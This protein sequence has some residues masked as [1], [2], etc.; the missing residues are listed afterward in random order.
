L[1]RGPRAYLAGAAIA[2]G[3]VAACGDSPGGPDPLPTPAPG[4]EVAVVVFYDEDGDG[5]PGSAEGARVPG[6]EVQIAGR[7]GQSE[8][9]T[10]RAVVRGVP[11]GTH[12]VSIRPASLP[13]FYSAGS[14]GTVTAPQPAGQELR[15]AVTL[16]ID[17]NR[18]NTYMAFGDSLTLGMGSSDGNG[19]RLVLQ[20]ELRGYYARGD[21]LNRG[22]DGTVANEGASRIGRGLRAF[23]P[24]YTLTLYGTNDYNNP[25]CRTDFPCDVIDSLETIVR[26]CKDAESLPVLAT[27]PPPNPAQE[28][29]ERSDWVARMNDLIRDLARSEGAV[30]ADIHAAF[31]RESDLPSLFSD[32]VHPNDRGY[33]IM[34]RVFFDS[35]RTPAASSASSPWGGLLFAPTAPARS[36]RVGPWGRDAR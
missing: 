24:A 33:A 14:A 35:I 25:A 26:S 23:R 6:V 16:P 27:I 18:P 20:D 2:S 22:G 30:L 19:Y 8:P 32:H 31:L 28:G 1:S 9:G 7:T 17:G 10:G 29:P 15:L 5:Q 12:A 36:L 21:V 11:A 3:L 34:A 4:F 13:P